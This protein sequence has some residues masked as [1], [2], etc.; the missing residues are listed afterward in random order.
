M[1]NATNYDQRVIN[2]FLKKAWRWDEHS[3]INKA[4]LNYLGGFMLSK[5]T[6]N[7][8]ID[9]NEGQY[10]RIIHVPAAIKNREDLTAALLDMIEVV[11]EKKIM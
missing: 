7:V 11:N 8:S 4:A 6:G 3:E 2:E 1:T 5:F 9:L 10:S